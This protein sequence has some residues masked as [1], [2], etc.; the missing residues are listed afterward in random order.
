ML[1]RESKYVFV[2]DDRANKPEVKKAVEKVYD[3]HVNDV[4]IL[5][6]AGKA[7][8]YGRAT[9]RTRSWKKAIVSLR[10]GEKIEGLIDNI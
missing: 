1:S 10:E 6:F 5:R 7:R 8:R 9:G 3:V 4:N 2:V